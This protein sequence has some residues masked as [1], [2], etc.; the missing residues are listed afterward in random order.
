MRGYERGLRAV[1][2]N[3]ERREEVERMLRGRLGECV[4]L[5]VLREELGREVLG[6]G[7]A[8]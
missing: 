2:E 6:L 4:E 5:M 7:E 3:V 1:C 8:V